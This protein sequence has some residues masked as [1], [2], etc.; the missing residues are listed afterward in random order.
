MG[1]YWWMIGTTIV[2]LGLFYFLSRG[3]AKFRGR[4]KKSL[5]DEVRHREALA[6]FQSAV[7]AVSGRQVV[8][9][10]RIATALEQHKS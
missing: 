2:A 5:D 9:L 3:P 10:E 8:A 7:L 4:I 6:S 1:D